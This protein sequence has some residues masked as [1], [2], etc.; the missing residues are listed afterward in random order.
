MMNPDFVVCLDEAGNTGTNFTDTEQPF[1]IEAGLL[2]KHSDLHDIER[3]VL[4]L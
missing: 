3:I 1:H 2:F 4:D